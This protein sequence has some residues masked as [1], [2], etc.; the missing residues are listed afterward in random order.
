[1]EREG[2]IKDKKNSLDTLKDF[3]E[4]PFKEEKR[5]KRRKY[6]RNL[7]IAPFLFIAV[8][9]LFFYLFSLSGLSEEMKGAQ[10]A[11]FSVTFYLLIIFTTIVY[12]AYIVGVAFGLIRLAKALGM[13][14]LIGD[15]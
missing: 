9:G 7:I 13:A 12:G 2:V 8:N 1:M 5:M 4:E 11:G 3:L 14:W 15:E 6:F 10:D